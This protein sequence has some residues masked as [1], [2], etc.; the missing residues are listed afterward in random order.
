LGSEHTGEPSED[1]VIRTDLDIR[2]VRICHGADIGVNAVILPGV[3]VGE[4]AVV[5]AASVVRRDVP[6]YA[7]VLGDPARVVR[8]RKRPTRSGGAE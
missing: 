4:N 6:A 2:P 7:V 1:A 3:T 5:G 8:R